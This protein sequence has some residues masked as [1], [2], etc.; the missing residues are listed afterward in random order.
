M[1][2]QGDAK[3]TTKSRQG[4]GR[5]HHDADAACLQR[6]GHD[7]VALAIRI[8]NPTCGYSP[9]G[10]AKLATGLARHRKIET[11]L[12]ILSVRYFQKVGEAVRRDW[13]SS[14]RLAHEV[15]LMTSPNMELS[16]WSGSKCDAA[17]SRTARRKSKILVL[18]RRE[19]ET[20]RRKINSHTQ[21]K[22]RGGKRM[23]VR[24]Q[25]QS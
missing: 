8:V 11:E 16:I 5:V 12:V 3:S 2:S 17:K 10:T 13:G 14:S 18:R 24:E 19:V 9:L 1:V 7:D 21:T 25:L 6:G 22:P 20:A 23:S 4:F 15:R